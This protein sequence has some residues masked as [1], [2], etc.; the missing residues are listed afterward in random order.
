LFGG[1]ACLTMFGEDLIPSIY[2]MNSRR[3]LRN[4]FILRVLIMRL[5][6]SFDSFNTKMVKFGSMLKSFKKYSWRFQVWGSR[7]QSSVSSMAYRD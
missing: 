1:V 6:P 7:M 5:G 3:T 4:N 2:K